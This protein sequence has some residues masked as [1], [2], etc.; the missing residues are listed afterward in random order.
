M[1][2]KG[3]PNILFVLTDQQSVHA[4]SCAG[5]PHLD[6][7]HMDALAASGTRFESAYC[8]A[9]VC[10]PSRGSLMTGRLPH[11]TGVL[12]NGMTPDPSIP[13]LGELFSRTGYRTGW[14]GRWHLPGNKDIHGFETLHDPHVRLGLGLEGDSRVTDAAVDFLRQKHQRPFCL[15]VSL[16][17]PHDIC[18]WIMDQSTPADRKIRFPFASAPDAADLPPL[19]PNFA[20]DPQEP[21][22]ISTCRQRTYYGQEGTFTQEWDERLW[23]TY[24]NAYYRLTETADVQVG[25]LLDTLRQQG[26]EQDTL[27]LFTSD[28]GEGMAAHHWVV[29]L[30]LYEESLRVPFIMRWPGEIPAGAVDRHHLVSGLDVL[31]TLCDWGGVDFRPVTGD[32]LRPLIENPG[33]KGRPFLVSEL[34]PDTQDLSMQGRMLRGRRF[35][36]VAFS[37]GQRPEM[38]FD[39]QTDPGEIRNLALEAS[40]DDE[41]RKHRALLRQWCTDKDDPFSVPL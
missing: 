30:M 35:K 17:N 39:L 14:S 40:W 38:L 5:N 32:S 27:V 41:L 29:K 22:F 28:H 15:G 19:P 12:V 21:E 1:D 36:Y 13:T 8:A 16:C 26:L 10:G 20:V 33:Q 34:Y 37:C 7:P 6:T 4:M 2:D 9:P 18:H 31:P 24:L 3:R 11:E 25:R 23:R